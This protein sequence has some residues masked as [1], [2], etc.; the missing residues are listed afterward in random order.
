[1]IK[2]IIFD[3]GNVLLD[4]NPE[5][6]LEKFCQSEEEKDWVRKEL[7]QGPEWEMGDRGDIKDAERY[8]LVKQRVPEKYWRALKECSFHWDICMKPVEG[9]LEFVKTVKELGYGIYVLS[10]ASDL[11]YQY[12]TNFT[13]LDYF[14]G[15]V[16]SADLKMLK[17]DARI[18]QYILNKYSLQANECLFIDDRLENVE[19]AKSVGLQAEQFVN[20]YSE[21][22]EKYI[23]G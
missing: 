3:M 6:P 20:N 22:Y 13:P 19:G 2:N 10:N 7:F 23:K 18:Y 4:F 1:M 8:D 5:V 12:F 16:V 15:I 14:D 9:A 17:P 21:I 11:F